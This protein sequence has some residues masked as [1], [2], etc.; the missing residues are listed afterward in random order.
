[1]RARGPLGTPLYDA[2][3]ALQL[4][5][6]RSRRRSTVYLLCQVGL[7]EDA[8]SLALGFDRAL[9]VAVANTPEDDPALQRKLWLGIARQVIDVEMQRG[10]QGVA[11]VSTLLKESGGAINI[12]DL[13]SLFPDFAAIDNFKG[14]IA[15]ALEDYNAQIETLKQEM[16][17]A[18]RVAEA[19]RRDL[20]NLQRRTATLDLSAPCAACGLA[21][22]APAPAAAGPAGGSVPRTLLFPT[23]NAYHGPCCIARVLALVGEAQQGRIRTLVKR[24]SVVP[25]GRARAPEYKGEPSA[26]VATVRAQLLAEVGGQD[27]LCSELLLPLLSQPFVGGEECEEAASWRV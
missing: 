27:P 13:L 6:E 25:E 12:E 26:P 15:A 10:G 11:H 5:Q 20:V 14:A 4:V 7:F 19:I 1:M 9:A 22:S 17:D 18:T 21:L 23:G 2:K 24:L 3:Y 16:V 8:V